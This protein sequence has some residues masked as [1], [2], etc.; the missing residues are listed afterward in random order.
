MQ[1][2]CNELLNDEIKYK[3]EIPINFNSALINKYK[4]NNDRIS[5]HQDKQPI[6]GNCP[7]IGAISLGSQRTIHFEPLL[8]DKN[9]PNS[10][11]RDKSKRTSIILNSGDLMIMAGEVNNRYAHAVLP[12]KEIKNQRYNI[13]FRTIK[14]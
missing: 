2:F 6:W 10:L 5:F 14:N 13:T 12:E 1:L 4:D 11:K 3:N 9:K 7:I 8:R